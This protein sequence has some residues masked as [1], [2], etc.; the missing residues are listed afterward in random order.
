MGI[1]LPRVRSNIIEYLKQ[2]ENNLV[3]LQADYLFNIAPEWFGRVSAGI[4]EEMYGGVRGEVL[5]RPFA[6]RWAV[7]FDLNWLRQRDFDQRLSFLEGELDYR[8]TTG[9]L[10][11]YYDVPFWGLHSTV[12]F[13]RYLARDVGATIE[14]AREFDGGIVFGVF[15]TLTDVPFE[16]F[17]EGSFDKGFFLSIPFDVLITS[18]TT[19]S[20]GFLFRPLSRDGG[21]RLNLRNQL[22]GLTSAYKLNRVARDWHRILD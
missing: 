20:A 16:E 5:Y 14:V 1:L 9:H 4:F 22:Y 21:Q 17:G 2:G 6:E 12:R 11:F 3:H 8:V 19:R 18:A 7:G 10:S 15:A 13:G